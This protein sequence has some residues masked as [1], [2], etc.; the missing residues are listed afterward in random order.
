NYESLLSSH[1]PNNDTATLILDFDESE[2][3]STSNSTRRIRRD[4]GEVTRKPCQRFN[5]EWVLIP[6]FLALIPV[7]LLALVLCTC[8][9]GPEESRG[10]LPEN[11]WNKLEALLCLGHAKQGEEM[12]LEYRDGY[13]QR[14]DST[15]TKF[16]TVVSFIEPR[17]NSIWSIRTNASI[18]APSEPEAPPAAPIK[19][20]SS[21]GSIVRFSDQISVLGVDE[22][23]VAKR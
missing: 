20:I 16:S 3:S 22:L 14:K 19:K 7:G 9:C 8:F 12:E 11:L 1:L 10:K 21:S 15:K 5:I 17:R 6:L 2:P 18:E 23:Q 13:V 4:T